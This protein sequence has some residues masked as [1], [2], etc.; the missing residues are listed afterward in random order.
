LIYVTNVHTDSVLAIDPTTG[1]TVATIPVG[2]APEGEITLGNFVY[3]TDINGH[4][5][6]VIDTTTNSVTTTIPVSGYPNMLALSPDGTRLYAGDT[7]PDSQVTVISTA[8]NTV[9]AALPGFAEAQGLA[10]SPDGTRLYV[11]NTNFSNPA[12]WVSVIDTATYSTIATIPVGG[13]PVGIALSPDGTTAYV[14]NNGG[15]PLGNTVAVIDTSTNTVVN[16]ITV[17]IN[18]FG[19]IMNAAGTT[20]YVANANYWDGGNT[21]SVPGS[22]SVID[23]ASGTVTATIPVGYVPSFLAISPDGGKLYVSDQFSG[24]VAVIDVT[25][26]QVVGTLSA[27]TYPYGLTFGQAQVVTGCPAGTKANFRWHYSANGSAGGWSGTATQA[28]P[29]GF[30]MG[31]QAMEGH[32]TVA[33]GAT[34]KA[35]YDFTLPGNKNSLTLGVAAAQVTFAVSCVSG[36]APSASTLTVPMPAQAYQVANDQ[37]YPSGNQS[38]PLVYQGSVTVPDLCG[39]GPLSLAHG[40]TFSAT[41]G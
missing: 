29:G 23:T 7:G 16:E 30:S 39:G 2:A 12:G 18:P 38:S 26:N 13:V 35:G 14:T 27:G 32:L 34:L 1:A 24:S 37:W 40:G 21:S 4:G 31:P 3:V 9:I 11:V 41:L 17:G 33:P 20:V 19:I 25:T 10:V 36:A 8:T 6:S 15:A 22:V 5:I 28:C